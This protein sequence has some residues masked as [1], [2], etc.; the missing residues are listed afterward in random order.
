MKYRAYRMHIHIGEQ[1]NTFDPERG[2]DMVRI[3]MLN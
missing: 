2:E 3:R 1:N